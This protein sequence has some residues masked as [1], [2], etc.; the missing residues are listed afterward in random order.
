MIL[1]EWFALATENGDKRVDYIPGNTS[2]RLA[3]FPLN[4]ESWRSRRLLQLALDVIPWLQK[5][6]YLLFPSIYELEPRAI[7]ALRKEYTIPIY[8]IG[9]AIPYFGHGNNITTISANNGDLGYMHWLDNQP[10][11]SVLYV[12]QGSFLS[13]SRDQID[14]IAGGLRESGVRFLWVQRGEASKLKEM[15]GDKGLVL[16]WCDQLRVLSHDA[17]GGFW[18]HCGWNSTREGVVSGVLFLAFPLFMDQ[19]LN[20]KYIV[21]DWKV[22]W[23]V[24]KEAK[25]G[26]LI[27]RD[28]IASLVRKCMD[29]DSVEGREM[30]KRARELQQVCQHAIADGGSSEANMNAF[31]RDALR[32]AKP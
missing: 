12:S 22:G 26:T 6:Q 27:R 8:T 25:Q 7:D 18:S 13:T 1:L 23:R 20:G 11:G 14:E 32:G 4:D 15:C 28:E 16:P 19:P 5:A 31:M 3:D 9:P 30:R 24:K 10:S 29:L 17:V 2:I 21:E